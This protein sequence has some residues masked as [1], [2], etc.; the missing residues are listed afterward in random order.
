MNDVHVWIGTRLSEALT[1]SLLHIGESLRFRAMWFRI[2]CDSA[3]HSTH[4]VLIASVLQAALA[5]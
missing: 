4:Y 3:Y 1:D 5:K 2:A